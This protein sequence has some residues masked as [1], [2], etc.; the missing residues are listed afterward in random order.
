MLYLTYINGYGRC[1]I[2]YISI[3]SHWIC[4]ALTRLSRYALVLIIPFFQVELFYGLQD[5]ASVAGRRNKCNQDE[6]TIRR[7]DFGAF[8]RRRRHYIDYV[9]NDGDIDAAVDA[10]AGK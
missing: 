8:R 9:S 1:Q 5:T 4:R 10:T 3:W 6:A 7:R 2:R